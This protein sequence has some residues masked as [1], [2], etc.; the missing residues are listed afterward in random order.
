MSE[1]ELK[2]YTVM[3]IM[4]LESCIQEVKKTSNFIS[5]IENI[6]KAFPQ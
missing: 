4:G 3:H 1:S 2:N 5:A 6:G